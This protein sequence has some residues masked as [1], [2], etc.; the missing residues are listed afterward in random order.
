M[1]TMT[2]TQFLLENDVT[3]IEEEVVVSRRIKDGEGNLLKFKIKPLTYEQY[4]DYQKQCTIIKG[5]EVDFDYRK[6]NNLLVINH[7]LEPNF[8]DADF[9]KQVGAVYPE[10]AIGKVLLAGE[11][12]VLAE[13]IRKVSGFEDSLDDLAAQVKN[14]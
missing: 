14:S 1:A 12:S 5:K 7:T 10:Q 11:I 2:L 3:T 6:F 13:Q 9:V 4:T 8:K